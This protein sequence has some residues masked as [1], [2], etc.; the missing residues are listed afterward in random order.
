[1]NDH[2]SKTILPSQ[3]RCITLCWVKRM[4]AKLALGNWVIIL[5]KPRRSF[6]DISII[7]D[8]QD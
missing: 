6:F 4:I 7:I 1:M 8:M 3:K 5:C 2:A